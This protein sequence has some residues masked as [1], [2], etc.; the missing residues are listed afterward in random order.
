MLKDRFSL[1]DSIVLL[2]LVQRYDDRWHMAL[3]TF[4]CSEIIRR[5]GTCGEKMSRV[6]LPVSTVG[7]QTHRNGRK[8]PKNCQLVT[9]TFAHFVGVYRIIF[10]AT[11]VSV[12]QKNSV[13]RKINRTQQS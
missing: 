8:T 7:V 11:Y 9:S 2:S 10:I 1:W 5:T 4:Q 6:Q 13:S 3:C 12:K